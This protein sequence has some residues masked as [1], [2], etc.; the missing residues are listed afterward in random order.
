MAVVTVFAT[1]FCNGEAICKRVAEEL[2]F[3]FVSDEEILKTAGDSFSV[4]PKKLAQAMQ[5]RVSILGRFRGDRERLIACVRQALTERLLSDRVVYI[6]YGGHLIPYGIPHVLKTCLVADRSFRTQK[7][8]EEGLS[9]RQALRAIK[10]DDDSRAQW[11]QYHFDTS[12]WDREIYDAKIPVHKSSIDEVVAN[13]CDLATRP[14]IEKTIVSENALRD[15][16]TGSKAALALADSGYNNVEVICES[17]VLTVLTPRTVFGMDRRL[18]KIERIVRGVAGV[19]VVNVQTEDTVELDNESEEQP[20]ILL[21]DDEREFIQTLSDRLRM[22]QFASSVAFD[23]HSALAAIED[24]EP[25]IMVLDLRMPGIDGL[26]VLRE[27]K[28]RRPEIEVIILSGEGKE[29][30]R[31]QAFELGAFAYLKKPV[32]IELLTKTMT[33]AYK[34]I[35][36]H[37]RAQ[38]TEEVDSGAKE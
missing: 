23:G 11:T 17:G 38:H 4:E 32:K 20:R 3:D 30:D 19:E 29:D 12:P 36:R 13:L 33:D 15:F 9:R 37:R 5:N 21:V 8:I 24:E 10:C 27:I 22:R 7:A 34:K 31:H 16:L 26:E 35:V 2:G 28:E 25:E 1:S 14:E 18:A 6:G